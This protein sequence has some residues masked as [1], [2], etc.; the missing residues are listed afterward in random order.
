MYEIEHFVPARGTSPPT[1]LQR[2]LDLLPPDVL[3]LYLNSYTKPGDLVIDPA[4]QTPT[5]P[6]VAS[7]LGRKALACNFNPINAL[8]VRGLLTLPAPEEID[9]ATMRLADS[10]K[11]GVPLRDH[12]NGLYA[13]TCGRCSHTV[14]AERFLWDGEQNRPIEK[15][16]HCPYCAYEG[17]FGVDDAD[18]QTL[19]GVESQGVHFWYLMER[20][21]QPHE[22]ERGLA[23]E[24]LQLYTPRNLYALTDLSMRI[25]ALFAGSPLHPALELILLSC[26]DTCSKLADSPLPRAT[27][28]R[29]QPPSRFVE[30][31][32]WQAFEEAYRLLR[33][34]A[35]APQV[36]M[37]S[38]VERLVVEGRSQTLVLNEP[39]RRVTAMLP[40][41]SVGLV[42]GAPQ[43]Y[44]RPF[45]T[46]SYLWSGWLW[47]R[48]KASLFK[49][50]LSR[51]FLG[52]SWY[53]H[54]T[55]T[56]LRTLHRPLKPRGR[57]VFL[58]EG[59][60]LNHVANLV[61]AAIGA[62]FR[63][64]SMLY[65]PQDPKPP[66]HPMQ[67]VAGAYRLT[68]SRDD[69]APPMAVEP[70][71]ESL[72][73]ALRQAA[74]GAIVELLRERGQALHLGWLHSVVYERWAR[75]GLL[76]Q[77]LLL[78]GEFSPADFLHE[79]LEA[80]LEEDLETGALTLLP[81]DLDDPEGPQVWWLGGKGYPAL[82]LGDRV[83]RSVCQILRSQPDLEPDQLE[84]RI[85][86]QFAGP[87]TP[88]PGLVHKC[89]ESYGECTSSCPTWRLRTED[90]PA[91]LDRKREEALEILSS[92]GG[93]LGF[94]VVTR[95]HGRRGLDNHITD[96]R[97]WRLS[98]TLDVS[99]EDGEGAC[100]VFAIKHTTS[101]GDI[102]SGMRGG[103]DPLQRYIV[104]PHRRLDL[105]RFRIE[106]ELLLR[107]A[108]A[109]GRW[110][111]IKLEH[112]RQLAIKD[113]L[114][115]QDLSLFV[116]LEPLIERPEAQLPLFS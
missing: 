52:W 61:L 37:S 9:G 5:L 81:E 91:S 14:V 53:R 8:L 44:Y 75:R 103:Q 1:P 85:Y 105:L 71:A 96:Q 48:H 31:N 55:A 56:A 24:L 107:V 29:L 100:H 64:D 4:A 90:A 21:A 114:R 33:G 34:L 26:L 16:Y 25:E 63:L 108:L 40:P 102:L 97:N 19:D 50:L 94:Q 106:T 3:D 82:P 101:F 6:L 76:K 11:R 51:R 98:R 36:T 72:A 10:L 46:L 27:A 99:W 104:V 12:I 20:L 93:R 49:P 116:G 22:A 66:R 83:E 23:E 35:P 2:Y 42:I 38:G 115:L 67:G 74:R 60:D 87:F 39:L 17:Q 80:T 88:G 111:F 110:Q 57:M 59:A 86:S 28:L 95:E 47:G 69:R 79:Q 84:N 32:V 15:K 65:Q 89:L 109:D 68:F 77:A 78:E 70:S 45:W 62:A 43:A 7:R 13:T 41:A 58:L 92:V 113:D 30:R 73:A 54:A 18:L 112:L